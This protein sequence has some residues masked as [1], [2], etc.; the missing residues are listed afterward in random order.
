[1]HVIVEQNTVKPVLSSHL[2]EAQNGGCLAEVNISTKLKFGNILYGCSRQVG[3]LIRVTANSGLSVI[4]QLLIMIP[5]FLGSR[6][7][8]RGR[9]GSWTGRS[10]LPR[11]W[12]TKVTDGAGSSSSTPS[13]RRPNS[14]RWICSNCRCFK[15]QLW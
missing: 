12:A 1:V 4:I 7:V 9:S 15:C 14:G 3:C 2:K 8:S 5:L 11:S 6:S 13:N 10:C